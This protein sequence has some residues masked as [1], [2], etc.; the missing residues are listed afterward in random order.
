LFVHALSVTLLLQLL[1][2]A[3]AVTLI[4]FGVGY[5]RK[6]LDRLF[7]AQLAGWIHAMAANRER[8]LV[9]GLGVSLLAPSS[10][11]MALLAVH[12]VQ[13][14][15]ATA[16]QMLAMMLGAGI[17]LT[18]TIQLVALSL[19]PYAPIIILAGFLLGSSK[20]APRTRQVGRVVLGLG[21]IFL[22]ILLVQNALTADPARHG[23]VFAWMDMVD[24]YEWSLLL[25]SL[26]LSLGTQS[27]TA[28]IALMIAFSTAAHVSLAGAMTW[29]VGANLG[30]GV[31]MLLSG[32][33]ALDSRRLGMGLLL[34]QIIAATPVLIWP[35]DTA[36]LLSRFSGLGTH[37]IANAHT[38]FNLLV[39]LLG[40]PLLGPIS[41][42]A[43]ALA[44]TPAGAGQ[45]RYEPH[46]ISTHPPESLALAV[47]QAREEVLHLG[48]TVREDLVAAWRGVIHLD[49]VATDALRHA[50]PEADRLLA[51]LRK[52]L[53]EMSTQEGQD[54]DMQSEPMAL[55]RMLAELDIIHGVVATNLTRLARRLQEGPIRFSDEGRAELDGYYRKVAGNFSTLLTALANGDTAGLRQVRDADEALGHEADVLRDHH[56]ERLRRGL[57]TSVESSLLHLEVL[58]FLRMI[59]DHLAKL[60]AAALPAGGDGG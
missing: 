31:T 6:A 21:F 41:R 53:A 47:T 27:A 9:S 59:H 8:A 57:P 11:T 10:T 44:P 19:S 60:A 42:A 16:V 7:G 34:A 48:Q 37:A 50:R 24:R 12:A 54:P 49:S 5:L 25:A 18:V 52:F 36:L 26:A 2:M 35:D 56:L 40:L 33:G 58:T 32:W 45:S 22:G 38:G 3:G 29:V 4:L 13:A 1:T 14:R 20:R 28:T 30:I 15:Q 55:A 51:Q 46:A 17:G 43:A 23:A 39:A